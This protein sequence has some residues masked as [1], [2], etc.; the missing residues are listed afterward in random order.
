M[1]RRLLCS[2]LVLFLLV[3]LLP[4][5]S[6]GETASAGLVFKS[7]CPSGFR[8]QGKITYQGA[9]FWV[10]PDSPKNGFRLKLGTVV[11]VTGISGNRYTAE[12]EGQAGTV[13]TESV[14]LSGVR[15]DT[16]PAA[17]CDTLALADRLPFKDEENNRLVFSGE[18]RA[19]VSLDSLSIFIWDERQLG[20]EKVYF[21]K[22]K[23]PSD[24]VNADFIRLQISL[25]HLRGGR[26]TLVIQGNAEGKSMVLYRELFYLRAPQEEPAHVTKQCT[27]SASAKKPLLDDKVDSAWKPAGRD[28]T[29]TVAIP[30][31]LDAALMTLEWK[32][33]PDSFTA[34]LTG[35][36]GNVL[37]ETVYET[38]F[39]LDS[40]PL[41]EDVASVK[42]TPMGKGCA[43]ST[44][45]VYPSD[46]A[47]H[48]VQSW[49]KLP[50]KVDMMLFSA[51][52]DDE[53][54]F[55]GGMI[56]YYSAVGKTVAVT[57][58]TNCNRDRYREALDGLWTTGLRYHPVFIG[59]RDVD[60]GSPVVGM[61]VWKQST[62][63]PQRDIVRVIR[64]YR[65]D[66]IATHD[67]NGEY[68]HIQHRLTAELVSKGAVL[69]ADPAYDPDFG[70]D[71]WE[72]KKVYSHLYEKNQIMLDWEQPL[73]EGTGFTPLM[74][75][76]EAY[77][78]HQS[79]TYYFT[80]ERHGVLYDNHC[81]GLVHSTVGEDVL[82]NDIFENVP[83]FREPYEVA[84]K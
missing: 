30:E 25:K 37:S 56:P 59:W 74:L 76:A 18:L 24:T 42:I 19:P 64:K 9:S 13:S 21:T 28:T 39:Y 4:G 43:L 23:T 65:P 1:N 40:I 44:L 75:A 68:G 50:D 69:A 72:V 57:Y 12:Y 53:L 32:K 27:I 10:M 62:P 70:Q 84:D 58:M 51:H 3:T 33:L 6:A 66:V 83:E 26:K 82:K 35:R 41:T 15:D 80:M 45:R 63:D 8:L 20:L 47:E 36:D 78:K 7:S 17:L 54:L 61:S 60:I 46:Y 55:F 14:S 67:F 29:I 81:F 31:G 16:V 2:L 71:P 77:Q 38:G 79:Q 22:L 49:K 34:V 73:E 11:T 52:Q 5:V 48:A